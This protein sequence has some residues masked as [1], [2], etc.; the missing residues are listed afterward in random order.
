MLAEFMVGV[1]LVVAPATAPAPLHVSPPPTGAGYGAIAIPALDL[2]APIRQL[3]PRGPG[4]RVLDR[5]VGHL[6]STYGPG[7]GGTVALFGHRITPTLGLAH[8]P[9]RY[10]D[11]LHRGDRIIVR[12]PYGRYVYRVVGHTVV[13]AD[14]WRVFRPRLGQEELLLAACTPPGKATHRYV[15]RAVAPRQETV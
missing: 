14:A 3:P 15:V 5:S 10:I 12:M 11:R 7:M 6:P 1:A 8:G 13:R 2:R 4:H 9:F